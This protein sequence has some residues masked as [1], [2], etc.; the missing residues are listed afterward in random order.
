M[1]SPKATAPTALTIA[2]LDPSG[3]AGV[4]A[5]V[6]TFTAFGCSPAA[7]ITSI[8]FQNDKELLGAEHLSAETIRGQI[9]A[10][11]SGSTVACSKT[12]M[13][14]TREIVREVARLF[15]ETDLPAPV[16][17]PVIHSTSGYPLIE[18]DAFEDL[19]EELLPLARLLT[20]NIPE[21]ER[22][23]GRRI[24]NVEGMHTAAKAIR[25]RGARA[26]L[27]K[28]GHLWDQEADGSRQTPSHAEAIDVLDNDG[29][30]TV[31][32]GEWI[33][34]ANLRG[35]GC[36]L[37]AAI[38]ACLGKGMALEE[39]VSQAKTFVARAVKL[40]STDFMKV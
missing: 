23:T 13:L 22:M 16:V 32:R 31:L 27:I 33:E 17:D 30:V 37:S 21:A 40:S 34:G 15:R 29:N 4:I 14:A 20:P 7:A 2:G 5:D 8:T 35:T 18:D 1:A 9:M 28:G 38:A 19:L 6:R 39:S 10:I 12:G 3:G 26:V 25:E 24:N 36:M 11:A